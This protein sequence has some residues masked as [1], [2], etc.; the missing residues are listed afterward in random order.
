MRRTK[1]RAGCKTSIYIMGVEIERKFLLKT[2]ASLPE[3][4]EVLNIQQMCIRDSRYIGHVPL[5]SGGKRAVEGDSKTVGK[6]TLKSLGK[7]LCCP[8]SV[9]YTHLLPDG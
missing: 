4:D 6:A 8:P 7:H 3:S 9:S 5:S 2:G 1:R